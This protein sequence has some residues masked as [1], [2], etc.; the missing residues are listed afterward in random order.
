MDRRGKRMS[1]VMGGCWGRFACP[2]AVR[3]RRG[4][5]P[6]PGPAVPTVAPQEFEK[7]KQIY[8]D[9]CAGCHGTLR[10]G[11]T[12]PSLLPDKTRKMGTETLKAFITYG[13]PGGMPNWGQQGILT[14][15]ESDLMA[16]YIQIDAPQPPEMSLGD[17]K[18]SWKLIVPPAQ[19]P[20]SPSTTWT[21]RTSSRSRSVT[22]GRWRSSTRSPRRS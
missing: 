6:G 7:A 19:R 13:T 2:D 14:E 11:A 20:K 21:G 17:M 5:G 10:K 15:A 12:G 4:P 18:K 1:A 3:P 8:F 16:R 22:R 9:R